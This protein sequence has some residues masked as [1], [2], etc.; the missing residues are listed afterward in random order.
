MVEVLILIAVPH[1]YFQIV[2]SIMKSFTNTDFLFLFCL[3]PFNAIV[4]GES[5]RPSHQSQNELEAST[6]GE[7]YLIHD[8]SPPPPP[9]FDS[10][11]QSQ[12]HVYSSPSLS[13]SEETNPL[14]PPMNDP[15][16]GA[17]V[18][19]IERVCLVGI[20]IC[21]IANALLSE[22][23][24]LP[25]PIPCRNPADT[26][27]ESPYPFILMYLTLGFTIFLPLVLLPAQI[28]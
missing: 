12:S 20:V 5:F 3:Q 2:C 19:K 4:I 22:F 25:D 21:A 16:D 8:P 1:E 15:R 24:K 27:T 9:P 13:T 14:L 10:V 17:A 18:K 7:Y 6:R 23:L 26:P 28:S 11:S